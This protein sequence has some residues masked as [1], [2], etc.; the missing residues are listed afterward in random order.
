[1]AVDW[2]WLLVVGLVCYGA[3]FGCLVGGWVL[4]GCFSLGC[5][6]IA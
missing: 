4:V 1:M 3:T 6:D 5:V 2:Q